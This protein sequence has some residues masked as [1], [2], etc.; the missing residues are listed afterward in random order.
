MNIFLFICVSFCG[1]NGFLLDD[2]TEPPPN[3]GTLMTDKHYKF[4][5]QFV[6]QERQ[7]RLQL[8]EYTK[9][10]KQELV[11]TK[12]ELTTEI[13]NLKQCGC[14]SDITN[15]TFTLQ[16]DFDSLKRDYD[17]M[18]AK[19]NESSNRAEAEHQKLIKRIMLV[20][21]ILGYVSNVIAFGIIL[22]LSTSGGLLDEFP[23]I[24]FICVVIY[25]FHGLHMK[26]C[27]KKH[28]VIRAVL[29]MNQLLGIWLDLMVCLWVFR[30]SSWPMTISTIVLS[31][32]DIIL[33]LLN[34]EAN[35]YGQ[36]ERNIVISFVDMISCLHFIPNDAAANLFFD[37]F[38]T[39]Y[40]LIQR[41]MRVLKNSR[42]PMEIYT[43][44]ND[45]QDPLIEN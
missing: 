41:N 20:R 33:I 29:G 15:K 2:K 6:I 36:K 7:S 31:L 1:C 24:Y 3:S 13:N 42:K 21:F 11:T 5:M 43:T 30:L 23:V 8:E 4:V 26:Y 37:F 10:L 17:A 28:G 32:I 9:Q 19:Y 25:G 27:I 40:S 39:V 16:K 22:F 38:D 35:Y 34:L 14:A 12:T 44:A 45:I 18:K